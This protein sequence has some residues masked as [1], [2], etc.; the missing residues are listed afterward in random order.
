MTII[1]K[2]TSSKEDV[3]NKPIRQSMADK[4]PNAVFQEYLTWVTG[5]PYSGQKPLWKNSKLGN[6]FGTII[7]LF[8]GVGLSVSSLFFNQLPII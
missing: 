5:K 2:I 4:F 8:L 3:A 1:K 7:M 6:L